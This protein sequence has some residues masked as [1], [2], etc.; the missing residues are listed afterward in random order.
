MFNHG[1]EQSSIIIIE[2]PNL[3]DWQIR[4]SIKNRQKIGK[5]IDEVWVKAVSLM[6]LATNPQNRQCKNTT[7]F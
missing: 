4:N 5:Q 2:D 7:F 3:A 6:R 1:L